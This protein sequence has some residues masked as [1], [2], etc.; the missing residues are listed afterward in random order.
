MFS[1]P[2]GA[3]DSDTPHPNRHAVDTS[4]TVRWTSSFS[5]STATPGPGPS[6]GRMVSSSSSQSLGRL[7]DAEVDLKMEHLQRTGSF[8]T[9]GAYH[10]LSRLVESDRDIERVVAASAGNHAQ[11]V[12][13]AAAAVDIAAVIVMPGVVP[14]AKIN[15]ARGYGAEVIHHG[16]DFRAAVEHM[17]ALSEDHGTEIGHAYDDPDIVTGQA[18][19]GLEI[20]ED[21]TV[22]VPVGGGGLVSGIACALAE[23]AP[24]VRIIGLQADSAATVPQ[25]LEKDEPYECAETDTIADG[26]ATGGISALTYRCIEAHVDEVVTVPDDDITSAVLFLMERA[27][28]VVE[29]AGAAAVA[30][31][32]SDRVAVAGETVVPV[33]SGGNF[34]LAMLGSLLEHELTVRDRILQLRVHVTDR[35]GVVEEIAGIAAA[36]DANSR[37]VHHYRANTDLDVGEAYLTFE[38]GTAG[39]EQA[40]V[41]TDAIEAAEYEVSQVN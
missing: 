32:L 29:R 5:S 17:K 18:T 22:V 10:K 28:Q 6:G 9:R 15:A 30:P 1:A 7:V 12:S 41:I 36:H 37:S 38:V 27:K 33:L 2:R 11:G 20:A 35:P 26:M 16:N 19:V 24:D 34:D 21:D 39:S 3:S 31:L 14:Q 40:T 13:L 25:S 23:V 4:P 8:K